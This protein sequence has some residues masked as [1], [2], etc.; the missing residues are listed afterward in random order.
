MISSA[1]N[2]DMAGE[3]KSNKTEYFFA[4]G[5]EYLPCTVLAAD[6]QEAEEQW[7]KVRVKNP[8]FNNN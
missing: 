2:K 3:V 7:K 4:G 8:S 6:P 1:K 5:S